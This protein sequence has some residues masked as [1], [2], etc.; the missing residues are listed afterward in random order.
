MNVNE[1]LDIVYDCTIGNNSIMIPLREGL[2]LNEQSYKL[3]LEAMKILIEE[4]KDKSE[5]PKKLASCF[6]DITKYFNFI[7]GKYSREDE[8][9]LEDVNHEI[10]FLVEEL[11]G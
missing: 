9:K 11:F 3:F 8:E 5:V 10:S 6:I 2:G 1:A 7:E 4:Y